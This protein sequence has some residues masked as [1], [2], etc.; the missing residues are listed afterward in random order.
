M[1]TI[2]QLEPVIVAVARL[3]ICS[4]SDLCFTF[5]IPYNST[6]TWHFRWIFQRELRAQLE[7]GIA[8]E[9]VVIANILNRTWWYSAQNLQYAVL[10]MN[11]QE[12]V[13]NAMKFGFQGKFV[14]SPGAARSKFRNLAKIFSSQI[15]VKCCNHRFV[16]I[17]ENFPKIPRSLAFTTFFV[18]QVNLSF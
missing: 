3:H 7:D 8:Q 14:T 16:T 11:Y 9:R 2:G 12:Y 6:A 4:E 10:Y 15:F 17:L 13:N 1:L 5:H 18:K